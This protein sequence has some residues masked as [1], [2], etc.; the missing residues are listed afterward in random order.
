MK[1]KLKSVL[2]L[3][4]AFV[5]Q[6]TF[7]QERTVSGVVSDESGPLPGVSVLKKGTTQ[8]TETDFDGNYKIQAKQGDVLVFSFV[9]MET[10]EKTVRG[11]KSI[12]VSLK[13]GNVLDEVVVTALGL[14]KKKD[15]DLSSATTV[16]SDVLKRS[17]ETGVIQ[18]LAGKTSGLKITKANGDP[19]AGASIQIRGANTINGDSNP[20]IIVDGVPISNSTKGNGPDGVAQQSRLNDIN[21]EDIE[22][23]T[24][25]KGASAAAVWGTGAANGVIVITT[26]SAKLGEGKLKVDFKSSV[27][28]DEINMEFAKQNIYG[29]GYNG[30]YR[31]NMFGSWG[32]KISD[33][34]GG[35]DDVVFGNERFVSN[36]GKVYYPITKKN[37]KEVYN[38]SNRNLV[39]GTG[40]TLNNGITVSFASN[41]ASTYLSY[42]NLRQNGIIKG[43]SSYKRQN[44]RLNQMTK[45]SDKITL[46]FN[47]SYASVRSD[48]IQQG[49]NL[50]G[51][52]LGYLRNAPDF[53]MSDYKGTYYDS[54]NIPHK[55]AHRG[56]RNYLGSSAPTY[57]NPL[58][59]MNEQDNPNK[60]ER[61]TIAPQLL[62]DITDNTK[63]VARYG[64]DYYTDHRETFFPVNSAGDAKVGSYEQQDISEKTENLNVFLQSAFNLS[65]DVNMDVIVGGTLDKNQ[66]KR[67]GGTSKQFSNPEVGD[68]RIFSNSTAENKNI[69]NYKQETRKAGVYSTINANFYKQVFV[70]LTGRY[71]RPS[72]LEKNIFYPS[73]SLGWVFSNSFPK[74]D[75][76]SFG[77]LR[78][79]YGEVGI[80][81]SA[82]SKNTL[83][84]SGGTSSGMAEELKAPAYGN[85]FERSATLG[86]KD[87]KEER[88][89]EFEV[90]ADFR[91]FK[92]RV[93]LGVTYYNKRT[94]DAIL[95]ID[96]PN[97]TGFY[98]KLGNVAEISNKGLEI[99]LGLKLVNTPDWKWNLNVNYSHNKNVVESLNGAES[100]FL[101]G[102]SGTSSRAVE[103]HSV[104]ALWGTEF[105]KDENG[106]YE[107]DAN[108]FPVPNTKKTVL[109]DPNP[110]WI[111]GLGTVVSYKGFSLSA[112]FETSQ[113]NDHWFGT[114]GV[115]KFFGVHP[116]TA[117]E[118]TVTKDL[119]NVNG[120]VYA[121]GETFRG[122]VGNFGGD[123]VALDQS[124]YMSNGG[125]FGNQAGTFVGDA[126][127]TRLREL[128]LG[129]SFSPEVLESLKLSNLSL[130]VSGRNLY[131]WTKV[132]GFDPDMNLTGNKG[133]G[134]DYFTN[135]STRS[136]VFTLKL[137][138]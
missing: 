133:R 110:D 137:G 103:G 4:L 38:K 47:S 41:K 135:P 17:G 114:E 126:S 79:S 58:W 43:K 3:I 75:V 69:E 44:L 1:T 122:N 40:V 23:V 124:W 29:Q 18:G 27:S 31:N 118:V 117:N 63:L 102:F 91:F 30:A 45:L 104:G 20:L 19:G 138:F 96:V 28:I 61:F 7:A 52:Y 134:L 98:S 10:V 130:S 92:N 46:R 107:L 94:V 73:A 105:K 35:A 113:G 85:P 112:Q 2:T 8:G 131:V 54:N 50:N 136:Y 11:G 132:K 127:W 90:G 34:Q 82:Y 120:Q 89:K 128:S 129:Y 119:K 62:W 111:G 81:P 12:N 14:K 70:E 100:V 51:L 72:T 86:N 78:V 37:S 60:V 16:E 13:S 49:S 95:D 25:L 6:I 80:E 116:E 5:V 101:A 108:G 15:D 42:S 36:T 24:V 74:N 59:T 106:K 109:G 88:I 121:K 57:N 26:K 84:G 56:Y 65:D 22:S 68:L 53:D 97:S 67:I 93:N 21:Q 66:Y 76:L 77:K 115:L 33:R 71:E 39:F 55:N 123:D 64:L 125:G 99:D 87:L 83:Y 48:R 32:D 9:G